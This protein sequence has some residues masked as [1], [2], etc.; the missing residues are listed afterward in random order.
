MPRGGWLGAVLSRRGLEVL[1]GGRA[2]TRCPH[3]VGLCLPR[4]G[5]GS[6]R[7]RCVAFG[8]VDFRPWEHSAQTLGGRPEV[9]DW[10]L[11]S[12]LRR[13]PHHP[14]PL[15]RVKA[16]RHDMRSGRRR[17]KT[18]SQGPWGPSERPY[19]TGIHIRKEGNDKG[20]AEQPKLQPPGAP[21]SLA[22]VSC[23]PSTLHRTQ[24]GTW[25][26]S[27][28]KMLHP[29]AVAPG[30]CANSLVC[31]VRRG[32]MTFLTYPCWG[33][34]TVSCAFP[35]RRASLPWSGTPGA[36]SPSPT[37][38]ARP[39][40][41]FKGCPLLGSFSAVLELKDQYGFHRSW[42]N[43]ILDPTKSFK[44]TA[45]AASPGDLMFAAGTV[46]RPSVRPSF[47]SPPERTLSVKTLGFCDA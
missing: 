19:L 16:S 17:L 4:P 42:N 20:A 18:S 37:S 15:G 2:G 22:L 12:G 27:K 41:P 11:G 25:F 1:G 46:R 36:W 38:A 40:R 29:L 33:P 24:P 32:R 8:N 31:G 7:Q 45:A 10:G 47:S 39:R 35:R 34:S 3:R 5:L 30:L 6:R 23:P 21:R 26:V 43:L 28:S 44:S 14:E 13:S 9:G